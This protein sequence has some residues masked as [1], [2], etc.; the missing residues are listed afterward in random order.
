M[1]DK[2]FNGETKKTITTETYENFINGLNKGNLLLVLSMNCVIFCCVTFAFLGK[3]LYFLIL[4]VFL[5]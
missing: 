4:H 5:S 3:I 2:H 1:F